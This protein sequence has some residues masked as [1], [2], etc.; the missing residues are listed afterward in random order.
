MLGSHITTIISKLRNEY[1]IQHN[2]QHNANLNSKQRKTYNRYYKYFLT[3]AN[4]NKT[5]ACQHQTEPILGR[6]TVST[7]RVVEVAALIK[8]SLMAGDKHKARFSKG[9]GIMFRRNFGEPRRV[10]TRVSSLMTIKLLKPTLVKDT[11]Q[12]LTN[13]MKPTLVK[14]TNQ[15]Q[16]MHHHLQW[17]RRRRRRRNH[18]RHHIRRTSRMRLHA[19]EYPPARGTRN[20][21]SCSHEFLEAPGPSYQQPHHEFLEVPGPSYQQPHHEFLEVPDPTYQQPQSKESQNNQVKH[22]LP[23]CSHSPFRHLL[24]HKFLHQKGRGHQTRA[25]MA[26]SSDEG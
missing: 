22:H 19:Q 5:K 15:H 17:R 9:I 2:M 16:H 4:R 3:T 26:R 1:E 13:F 6:G 23:T 8:T 20:L 7:H 10:M 14:N 25:S 24:L 21:G 12:L 18:G 11:N